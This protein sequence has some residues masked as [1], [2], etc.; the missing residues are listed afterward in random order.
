MGD[1]VGFE[2]SSV[3]FSF[4]DICQTSRYVAGGFFTDTSGLLQT[5]VNEQAPAENVTSTLQGAMNAGN[6]SQWLILVRPQGV[7]EVYIFSTQ[8]YRDTDYGGLSFGR[9]RSS[10]SLFPRRCWPRWTLY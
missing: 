5:F 9:S 10:H 1:K 6:K 3:A 7:V 8:V 4:D 2:Q